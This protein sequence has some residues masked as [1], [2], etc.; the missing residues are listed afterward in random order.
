MVDTNKMKSVVPG[1]K[2]REMW[3]DWIER[4]RASGEN[5]A[6]FC[7]RHELSYDAFQYWLRRVETLEPQ[8]KRAV[9]FVRID[10]KTGYPRPGLAKQ[11]DSTHGPL[12]LQ[13]GE[14]KVDIGSGFSPD[15]L[16]LVLRV[17]R[18]V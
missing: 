15:D 8:V 10:D 7:R 18:R 6:V 3:L 12:R 16:L 9:T 17:L 4:W 2:G 11:V 5:R 14:Y 13:A 1:T